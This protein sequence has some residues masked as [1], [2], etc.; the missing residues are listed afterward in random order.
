MDSRKRR[1]IVSRTITIAVVVGVLVLIGLGFV[2]KPIPAAV[3]K[4]ER[5]AL[6][7]TVEEPGR[8]RIRSR[9]VIS[10]PVVGQLAR[11]DL[12]AG[13][14]VQENQVVAR[15]SPVAP[16][17]LDERTRAQASARVAVA[18][19]NLA[20]AQ[21]AI[22]RANTGLSFSRDQA[23]RTRKL[24]AQKG[25]SE[26]ALE[27]AEFQLR[28]AEEEFAS[29]QL[30]E[31]VAANELAAARAAL[32]SMSGEG[33]GASAL[34]VTAPVRGQVLKI[35]QE[36]EGVVQPGTPLMEIGDPSALE[37]VVDVLSTDAVRIPIGAPARIVRW[38][39][40][41]PIAAR[42]RR[43][44]PTAFT[45]RSA[46]GVEEQRVPVLLD[47]TEPR[48]Q[49]LSLGDG[50]RVEAHIQIAKIEDAVV[51]PASALFREDDGFVAF[52]V[53]DGV[54]RKTKVQTG[55]RTPDWV[56]VKGGL[57][58]GDE[59]VLYPSDKVVDGV[60]LTRTKTAHAA[61]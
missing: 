38:G 19:A 5:R 15:I 2:P 18:Q 21:A 36:S 6:E 35:F 20:R 32:A 44:E 41:R 49:W 4:V 42:V 33:G 53:R 58:A 28:S 45:T 16:Q 7:V 60:E 54:A 43:K 23:E 29:A 31:R 47:L 9:Y 34:P 3:G 14:Q 17:L 24:H 22:Q 25:T 61:R 55:A 11:I 12:R 48:E 27:Q 57:K 40:D 46:L 13:D 8:T 56:E 59:V 52:A 26:Q 10:A 30:G 51:V 37:I 1:R 39:G 50:Y